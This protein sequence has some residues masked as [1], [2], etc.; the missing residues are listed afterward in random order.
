MAKQ[1]CV[2]LYF[3]EA[4]YQTYE[5]AVVARG[6]KKKGAK[7]KAL[8]GQEQALLKLIAETA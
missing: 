6:A 8:V 3:D 5:A 4:D 2:L 7:S 1:R